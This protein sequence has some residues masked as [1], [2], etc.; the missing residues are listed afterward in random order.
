MQNKL[1]NQSDGLVKHVSKTC[2]K[3]FQKDIWKGLKHT[4]PFFRREGV[5]KPTLQNQK[6]LAVFLRGE[7]LFAGKGKPC[8][9]RAGQPRNLLSTPVPS[10]P[11]QSP[12][13]VRSHRRPGGRHNR[14]QSRPPVNPTRT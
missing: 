4:P 7:R 8:R 1:R 11:A 13:A 6:V 5:S 9:F 12:Q 2:F 3:M 14:I 10:E